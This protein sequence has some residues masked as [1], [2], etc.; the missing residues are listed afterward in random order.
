[1]KNLTGLIILNIII[2][3]GIGL[4]KDE[5]ILEKATFAAGCFCALN[6]RLNNWRELRK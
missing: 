4:T 3:T 1:M 5:P 2:L 6:I